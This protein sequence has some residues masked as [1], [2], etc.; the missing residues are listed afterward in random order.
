MSVRR[1][2]PF[3]LVNIVV[4]A[5]VVLA[6]LFWWD[7][8]QSDAEPPV[9]EPTNVVVIPTL[10][11][12]TV[13]VE[14]AS[15]EDVVDEDGPPVYTVAAGDTLGSISR[16]FDVSIEDI[17]LVN[18]LADPN[19]L[20]VNQELIIPVGGIPTEPPPDTP[21]PAPEV[22]PSPISTELPT[23]GEAV[24]EIGEVIGV[25]SLADE[26]VSIVNSGNR[27]IALLGWRLR[28]EEGRAYT[29]GQVTLFGEGA[30]V[31]VHTEAGLDGPADLYWGFEQPIWQEGETV[32]LIDAEGT[33]R[34]TYVISGP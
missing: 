12:T 17:M 3:V 24:V 31:L 18:G 32:T 7:S 16:E 6:I 4:S 26:A 1:I 22:T 25:G 2:L 8:R 30:A 11:A 23:E 33:V 27:P 5:I 13:N 14:E 29:F 10:V 9:V 34:A 19:F 20:Q 15:S 28:D 21:T